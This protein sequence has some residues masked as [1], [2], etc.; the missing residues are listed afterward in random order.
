MKIL[1]ILAACAILVS[2]CAC[3][4]KADN[5]VSRQQITSDGSNDYK[6]MFREEIEKD[7][8]DSET[9]NPDTFK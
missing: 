2:F 7:K 1:R 3:E 9:G 4:K 6:F 8:K 5:K